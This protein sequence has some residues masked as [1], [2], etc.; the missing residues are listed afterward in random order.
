MTTSVDFHSCESKMNLTSPFL[1][2]V[3]AAAFL[4]LSH[5]VFALVTIS[6]PPNNARLLA[7]SDYATEVLGD[8]WDMSNPEDISIVPDDR[9]GWATFSFPGNGT[10]GGTTALV[11][12]GGVD[13]AISFLNRGYYSILNPGRTGRK[14]P[15]DTSVYKKIAFRMSSGIAGQLPVVYWFHTSPGD[16]VSSYGAMFTQST[17]VGNKVFTADLS[18]TPAEGQNWTVAPV[19]GLRIDPN[20][21]LAGHDVFFDWVRLTRADTDPQAAIMP[22]AWSGGTGNA[23]VDVIDAFGTVLNIPLAPLTATS[24]NWNY[25]VLPPGN[26]QL[27]VTSGTVQTINFSINNPPLISVTDP[28]ETGGEDFATTVLSNPWDMNDSA[29]VV[30]TANATSISFS[31]G[32]F[33]A[34][35][36]LPNLGDSNVILHNSN[37][38]VIDTSKYRFLTFR[39]QLD[40]AYNLG[41]GSVARVFW[42]STFNGN[43]S[44]LTTT[45][46]IIAWPGTVPGVPGFVTYTIDLGQLT[47]AV[48]GGLEPTG[49]QQPWSAANNR[50]FRIDPHEF[51][52]ARSFHFDFVRLAA[53]REASGSFVIKY[54]ASDADLVD[55]GATVRLYYAPDKVPASRVLIVSSLPLSTNGQYTWNI[56]GVAP[57][58]YYIYA[59]ASDGLNT[60]GSYSSG[61]LRVNA[62]SAPGSPAIVGI[63]FGPGRATISFTAPANNGGSAITGYTA[64]CTAAGQTTRTNTGPGS[65]IVVSGLTGGVIYSCS[66]T[67]TN[68]AGTG[69]SSAPLTVTPLRGNDIVPILMLLLFD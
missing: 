57:G 37:T 30:A 20:G 47:T 23:T 58:T 8:P 5:P 42:S 14:F 35:S 21:T 17:V 1:S 12:G 44:A 52:E 65:P 4:V 33:N 50:I 34:T 10:V 41:A 6:S 66:V 29:D 27:R 53:M 62:V 9:N 60:I 2:V 46:D 49:A 31:G 56:S 43:G 69:P 40:G 19:V 15:I 59:E 36:A 32:I 67:A 55:S 11:S 61:Q 68:G 39:M 24:V 13:T 64:T 48:N 22:I 54:V 28:D 45:K 63:A 7:G 25:G 26:Y 51:N 16:P 38:T 3:L 18:Q